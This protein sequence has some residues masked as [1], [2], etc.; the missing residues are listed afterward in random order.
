MMVPAVLPSRVDT[1]R[2]LQLFRDAS[3]HLQ[4]LCLLHVS[5]MDAAGLRQEQGAGEMHLNPTPAYPLWLRATAGEMFCALAGCTA[6]L[7]A[8]V[9]RQHPRMLLGCF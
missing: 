4:M 5:T 6:L 7:V 8:A 3:R 2:H 9:Q 1:S